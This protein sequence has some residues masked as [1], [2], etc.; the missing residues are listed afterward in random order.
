MLQKSSHGQTVS[1]WV[2]SRFL[3]TSVNHQCS[4]LFQVLENS[5][6]FPSLLLLLFF[7]LSGVTSFLTRPYHWKDQRY[8][9]RSHTSVLSWKDC[10]PWIINKIRFYFLTSLKRFSYFSL[11]NQV[12]RRNTRNERKKQYLKHTVK[13]GKPNT[14]VGLQMLWESFKEM[15]A[16]EGKSFCE[17]L[18]PA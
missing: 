7:L 15:G 6:W 4:V 5:S 13:A 3:Q 17:T 11:Q 9:R 12:Q 2:S 14:Y 10:T 18:S 8:Q 16:S 1:M